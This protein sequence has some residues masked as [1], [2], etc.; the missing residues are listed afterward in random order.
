M[1]GSGGAM[2]RL[3]V[4]CFAGTYGLALLCELGRLVVR[5]PLRWHLTIGLTALGW[6]VH[7]IFL[8]NL[9]F[10]DPIILPVTTPF[11][12]M[13]VLAWIVALIGLYFMI[14]WPRQ[15]AVGSFVLPLVLGL[16]IAAGWFAPRQSDWLEGGIMAFWGAVHAVFLLAGAVFACLAFAAGLMYL[17][18]MAR[19]KAKRPVR[20]GFALPSLEHS[21]RANRVAITV[22]FPLLTFGLLIGMVL[23]LRARGTSAPSAFTLSWTDPKV[24]SALGMWVVFAVLLHARFRPAMRG[25]SVMILTIVA[26][27]FLVFT[28][29]GVEALQLQTAHGA[30][31][32]AGRS[33]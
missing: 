21:E 6:L 4:L 1:S 10:K 8:A 28:W 24:L 17:A 11:E 14:H 23:S 13:I 15:I 19:L 25:R 33:R 26:F 12:S 32:T 2:D 18:Q 30:A 20:F 27:A 3:K 7:T 29:V 16:V 31:G 22:A 9:A 5:N